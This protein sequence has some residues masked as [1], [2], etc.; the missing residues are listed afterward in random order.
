M[1]SK[2]EILKKKLIDKILDIFHTVEPEDT[3]VERMK[4][5]LEKMTVQEFDQYIQYLKSGDTQIFMYAP[6]VK[7]TLKQSNILNAA[8][9]LGV[10]IQERIWIHDSVTGKDYLTPNEY[11]ILQLPIRRVSQFLLH[12]MAVTESD[13]KIDVL[14]GQVTGDD[15]ASSLTQVEIQALFARD[16]KNTLI[17]LVKIRGGDIN[18]YADFKQQISESGEISL[19]ALDTSTTAR[20]VVIA[21]V[22]LKSMMIDNNL[23]EGV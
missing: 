3:N 4:A 12:K 1:L 18:A 19:S 6:N 5:F 9:K 16:L 8:K 10:L 2:N 20:S 22:L 15:R 17:E 21:S 7:T 14:S 13:K 23:Y 11:V